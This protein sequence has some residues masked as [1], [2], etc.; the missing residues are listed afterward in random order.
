MLPLRV[1]IARVTACKCWRGR[2]HRCPNVAIQWPEDFTDDEARRDRADEGR[3][4]AKADLG[5]G[6]PGGRLPSRDCPDLMASRS[7]TRAIDVADKARIS[8]IASGS[9]VASVL[10]CPPQPGPGPWMRE[11]Q[12]PRRVLPGVAL[13]N[14]K[15][16][17]T[18]AV[19][20]IGASRSWSSH[21]ACVC[22]REVRIRN[23]DVCNWVDHYECPQSLVGGLMPI[24]LWYF[25]Y[26]ICCGVC[27]LILSST[28]NDYRRDVKE[29]LD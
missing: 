15:S 23:Y 5:R 20:T 26:I 21:H 24:L 11:A 25:P 3:P 27:D 9:R 18:R 19:T 14:T 12:P 22:S 6:A 17:R 8:A 4:Q 29:A 10:P 1:A 7:R 13:R 28:R 16:Q 2:A